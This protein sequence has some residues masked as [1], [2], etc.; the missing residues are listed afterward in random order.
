MPPPDETNDSPRAAEQATS[1]MTF[2]L[3]QILL[4]LSIV[5][6]MRPRSSTRAPKA[7]PMSIY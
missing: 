1:A 6:P 3:F 7:S 5:L 4:R 2:H